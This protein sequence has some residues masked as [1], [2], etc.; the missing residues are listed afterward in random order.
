MRGGTK[1]I[2]IKYRR[3]NLMYKIKHKNRYENI[4][5]NAERKNI[6][7]TKT[8]ATKNQKRKKERRKGQPGG[9]M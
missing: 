3:A 6:K 1:F 5:A 2:K 8:N 9:Y 4:K 7:N